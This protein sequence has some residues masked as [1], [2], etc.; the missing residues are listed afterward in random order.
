MVESEST[1]S[2]DTTALNEQPS[3][4]LPRILMVDDDSAECEL[5]RMSLGRVGARFEIEA[6]GS[7]ADALARVSANPP[8]LVLSDLRLPGMDGLELLKR[9]KAVQPDLPVILLTGYA[10]VKTAV[11]AIQHGAYQFLTKPFQVDE[12]MVTIRRALERSTLVGELE[13]L[14]RQASGSGALTLLMG[15]SPRI[16]AVVR[17]IRQVARSGFSVL[18]Q[19]ET[20]CGKEL[21][22]RAIHEESPRRDKPL[23]ALDCGAIPETLIE[24]ELFGYER[25]AFSGADRRKDGQFHLAD[26]GTLFLDEIGNLPLPVQAKLLRAL[27]DRKI[28]SLGGTT[29]R[30][31]DVRFVA[32]TNISL[33][34]AARTGTFRQDLFYRLAE[35][36]I[37][38]PP[39]RER[40]EDIPALVARFREEASLELR[41]PVGG[42]EP[43]AMDALVSHAW[44]GNV[45]EL[46]NVVRQAVLLAEGFTIRAADIAGLLGDEAERPAGRSTHIGTPGMTASSS[47]P[48]KDRVEKAAAEAER[49]AIREALVVARGN[50]SQAA[51]LLHV[52]FKTLHLKMKRYGIQP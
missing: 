34:G 41:R 48:L 50:K 11:Q 35:F 24:S 36:T 28:L 29:A 42:L 32:A 31:I 19:G 5:V 4:A 43:A 27:Q 44:P 17:Q 30:S 26:G 22:A 7:A 38:V 25:G 15:S 51:R 21:V 33:D 18:I 39:L 49:E 14:R 1:G 37:E 52:H 23:I 3:G 9:L 2:S 46:R 10:E 16:Q 20:G 8:D 13:A 47:V 40:R 45:R 6:V 12:L